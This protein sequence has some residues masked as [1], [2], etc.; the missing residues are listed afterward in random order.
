ME[1]CWKKAVEGSTDNGDLEHGQGGGAMVRSRVPMIVRVQ[2][3][4]VGR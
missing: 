1:V 4:D 3:Y 2:W